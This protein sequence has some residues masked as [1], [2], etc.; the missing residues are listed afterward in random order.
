V[1]RT[2]ADKGVIDL[3]TTDHQNRGG[4]CHTDV[5]TIAVY[6]HILNCGGRGVLSPADLLVRRLA[7]M[8]RK[9]IKSAFVLYVV[10]FA[11]FIAYDLSVRMPHAASVESSL[12]AEWASLG[13][14]MGSTETGHHRSHKG[15]HALIDATFRTSRSPA[16][17]L[18]FYDREVLAHGW[19]SQGMTTVRDWGRDLGGV[20]RCYRKGDYAAHI[21]LAGDRAAY[22]WD[23]ALSLS[24]PARS[25]C[26]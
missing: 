12:G 17:V 6:T 9:W 14:P 3:F 10:G 26:E 18:E 21:Q 7:G 23:Y 19:S 2:D 16:E 4:I 25:D 15:G 13:H 22:G 11:L 1:C 20:I 24:W 5:R 8:A